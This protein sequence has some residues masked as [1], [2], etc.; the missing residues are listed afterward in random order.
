MWNYYSN[1]VI[2]PIAFY[3]YLFI[4]DATGLNQDE[5]PTT[6][7][8]VLSWIYIQFGHAGVWLLSGLTLSVYLL[9]GSS[10]SLAL[11]LITMMPNLSLLIHAGTA[12][13]MWGQMLYY[14]YPEVGIMAALYSLLAILVESRSYGLSYNAIL[15]IDSAYDFDSDSNHV[16]NGK[17]YPSLLKS[18]GLVSASFRKTDEFVHEKTAVYSL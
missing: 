13:T 9:T 6:G 18:L 17:Y 2:L 10:D 1:W 4:T 5:A 7:E 11:T 14:S 15:A 16:S 12:L 3:L 8:E